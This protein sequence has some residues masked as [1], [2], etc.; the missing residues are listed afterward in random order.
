MPG[1]GSRSAP[2]SKTKLSRNLRRGVGMTTQ[3]NR[4]GLRRFDAHE[5]AVAI[6][7][8]LRDVVVVIGRRDADLARQVRKAASS[9][10]ANVAEGN[11]RVGRDRIHLLRIASGSADEVVVHLRVAQAWGFIGK[12]QAVLELL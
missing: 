3:T 4:P 5:V 8:A 12:P 9:V 6:I 7:E 10:A 2:A 1:S 11:R